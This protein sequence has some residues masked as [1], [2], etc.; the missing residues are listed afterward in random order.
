[1]G[2]LEVFYAISI[3]ELNISNLRNGFV[4]NK[5]LGQVFTHPGNAL[6]KRIYQELLYCT[7]DGDE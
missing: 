1:M 6:I 2:G 4:N 5:P 7:V 3:N